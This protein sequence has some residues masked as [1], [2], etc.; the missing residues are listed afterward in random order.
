MACDNEGNEEQSLQEKYPELDAKCKK[1]EMAL[2]KLADEL[3][4]DTIHAVAT[5]KSKDNKWSHI[6]TGTGNLYARI[7]S[8][9]EHLDMLMNG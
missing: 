8:M 2:I 1:L 9:D 3:E 5:L 6:A 4:L 7:R